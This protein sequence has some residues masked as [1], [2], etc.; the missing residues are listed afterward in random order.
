[1]DFLKYLLEEFSN[2]TI[3]KTL[4]AQELDLA[5]IFCETIESAAPSI[6]S[7][8]ITISLNVESDIPTLKA[9]RIKLN[10]LF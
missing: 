9:D 6:E 8:N 3:Q 7:K 2:S 5:Q 1:M 10:S 4:R